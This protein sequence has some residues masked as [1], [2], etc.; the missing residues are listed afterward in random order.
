MIE[1][2]AEIYEARMGPISQVFQ[3]VKNK[4]KENN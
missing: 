3:R 1:E 4:M 2:A